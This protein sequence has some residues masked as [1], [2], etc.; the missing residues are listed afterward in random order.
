MEFEYCSKKITFSEFYSFILAVERDFVPPLLDRIDVSTYYEKL[1]L[2]ATFIECYNG[3]DLAGLFILYDNDLKTKK[4]FGTLLAVKDNYRGNNIAGNLLKIACEHA[5]EQGMEVLSFDTNNE[6]AR[7]CYIK[8][9]FKVV[10]S[11]PINDNQLI[12]YYLEKKL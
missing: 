11:H 12:R 4:A 8:N 1:N 9:G 7:D 10:E 3:E 2:F 5:K 6:V